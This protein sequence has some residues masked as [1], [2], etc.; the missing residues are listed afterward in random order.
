[1]FPGA[2]QV[3]LVVKN[4][5]ANAGEVRDA[6]LIPGLGK[7]LGG[8]HGNHLQYS[9]LENSRDRGAWR[10]TV[11][12]VTKSQARLKWLNTHHDVL[13][14][15]EPRS[16]TSQADSVPAEPPGN[17]NNTGVGSL[18]LLQQIFP[19]RN[20]TGVFCIAGG[21]FTNWAIMEAPW[22]SVLSSLN[23]L[24]QVEIHLRNKNRTTKNIQNLDT[25]D[26]PGGPV[27]KTLCS[28]CS[29][30]RFDP[31][32]GNYISC[33]TTKTQVQPN[34]YINILKKPTKFG[35]LRGTLSS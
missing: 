33:V 17:P 32:L 30:P 20:Q 9:C 2:S 25:W 13:V 29:G 26:F 27:A 31:W 10:A 16:P 22:C 5:P 3:A 1:M 8:G 35:D 15:I 14:G 28:Q 7:S 4:T 21:F 11:H 12:G 34:K 6:S 18:S 24:R 23:W 19:T